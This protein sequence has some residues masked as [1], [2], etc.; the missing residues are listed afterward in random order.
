MISTYTNSSRDIISQYVCVATDLYIRTHLLNF[1]HS[2][3]SFYLMFI[4]ILLKSTDD[5]ACYENVNEQ[6]MKMFF[7][8]S[9][10]LMYFYFV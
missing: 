4:E 7:T 9:Y 2:S 6:C 8:V 10:Y 5:A 3:F 1:D